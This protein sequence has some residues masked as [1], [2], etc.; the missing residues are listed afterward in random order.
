MSYWRHSCLCLF[1]HKNAEYNIF[2]LCYNL[3]VFKCSLIWFMFFLF[4]WAWETKRRDSHTLSTYTA[5][6]QSYSAWVW[7]DKVSVWNWALRTPEICE[8]NY[9][10]IRNCAVL[11]GHNDG[12]FFFF[13]GGEKW[14][15]FYGEE[16]VTF[17]DSMTISF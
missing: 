1:S 4:F 8:V 3:F 2:A 11:T 16:I 14:T 17:W 5:L 15:L 6:P 10:T 7:E 13:L 12:L 9:Y